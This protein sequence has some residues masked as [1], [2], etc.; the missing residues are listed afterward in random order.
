MIINVKQDV[1]EAY[2]KRA[3]EVRAE[4]EARG[5]YM[6]N[7]IGSPGSGKTLLLERSMER[8]PKLERIAV[9]EGDVET[10]RDAE[11]LERFGIQLVSVNTGGACHL[12]AQSVAGALERLELDALEL[13][14]IENVGNLI[15]PVEFDLGEAARV[16]VSSVPE[17]EDKPTKYP[18][19]F[20]EA[21]AV[22]LNKVDLAPYVPFDPDYFRSEVRRLNGKAPLFEL[23]ASN[24]D[25]LD[26]WL[27]WIEERRERRRAAGPQNE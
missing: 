2:R 18:A 23:S 13:I 6:V 12:E 4:L 26:P 9:I 16:A 7:L 10:Q 24:G 15:C 27:A 14:F 22:V 5:V 11:R 17:G 8:M 20:R 25:G 3:E 21:S 1:L 19:L